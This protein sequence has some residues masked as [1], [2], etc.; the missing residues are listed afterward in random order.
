MG[1]E[2][3]EVVAKRRP[4]IA[5]ERSPTNLGV[6]ATGLLRDSPYLS[7]LSRNRRPRS[8]ASGASVR[9]SVYT[10]LEAFSVSCIKSANALA[11][12]DMKRPGGKI[13]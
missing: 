3:W 9:A 4:V 7:L 8:P 2:G 1:A 11:A 5:R 13:A 12:G 6:P 10:I